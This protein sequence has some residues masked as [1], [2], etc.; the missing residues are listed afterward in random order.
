MRWVVGCSLLLAACATALGDD[1]P[2]KKKEELK[3]A[4]GIVIDFLN[5]GAR[6]NDDQAAVLL[7]TDFLKLISQQKTSPESYVHSRF[8]DVKA[9]KA[10]ITS[11][12]MAP[13][14]DEAV[15]RGT[16]A[17]DDGEAGFT[18]RVVKE[19]ESGKW[20]VNFFIVSDRKKKDNS[21]KK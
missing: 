13:D 7:S 2:N 17:A 10:S 14:Q 15:F 18:I 9:A 4:K 6:Q 20:R 21:S 12:E 5:A 16:F 11:E 3:W 8:F 19:K 1:K